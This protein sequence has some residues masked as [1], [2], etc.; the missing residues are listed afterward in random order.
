[1]TTRSETTRALTKTRFGLAVVPGA[2]IAVARI[3]HAIAA[4]GTAILLLP[5]PRDTR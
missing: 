2:P 4:A 5:L 3:A 1:V